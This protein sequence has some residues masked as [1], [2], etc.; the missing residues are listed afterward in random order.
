MLSQILLQG[1][2]P[3]I[4]PYT[5][6]ALKFWSQNTKW[7]FQPQKESVTYSQGTGETL[8]QTVSNVS[9]SLVNKTILAFYSP[10]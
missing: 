7:P 9:H 4:L 5:S 6:G 1:W 10:D 2:F 8:T 3:R